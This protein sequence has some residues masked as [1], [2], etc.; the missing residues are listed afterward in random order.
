MQEKLDVNQKQ[1]QFEPNKSANL[2]GT[3]LTGDRHE[4]PAEEIIED[5]RLFESIKAR[6]KYRDAAAAAQEAFDAAAYAAAAARA[7][8]ELSR[9]ESG[10][11]DPDD[12]SGSPHQQG[13]ISKSNE[14]TTPKFQ[15]D[16]YAAS[17]EIKHSNNRL[18]FDKIH[19]ID[20]F[21]SESDAN[22]S[23]ETTIAQIELKRA[24]IKHG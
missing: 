3:Q 11:N 10:D 18:S 16:G 21:S 14:S 17:R 6:K 9:S 2:E 5:E 24:K 1:K 12:Y 20:N 19:P 13:T 7:A 22:K 4:S 23:T 15:T 8:I